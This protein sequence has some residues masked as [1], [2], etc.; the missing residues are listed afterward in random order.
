MFDLFLV[1][2]NNNNNNCDSNKR[3]KNVQFFPSLITRN[4]YGWDVQSHP[5]AARFL[6]ERES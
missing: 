1:H 6:V 4:K 2:Y 5:R 3:N